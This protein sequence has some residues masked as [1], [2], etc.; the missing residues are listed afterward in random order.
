M[1]Q[2]NQSYLTRKWFV[3]VLFVLSIFAK[4]CLFHWLVF[5]SLLVSSLWKEPI[6]FIWFYLPKMAPA[7]IIGSFIFVSK[8][9]WW[10][11]I[12]NVFYDIWIIANLFY[13]RSNELLMNFDAIGMADNMHGFWPSLVAYFRWIFL[14]PLGITMIYA[15][16][17]YYSSHYS[18]GKAKSHDWIRCA[19]VFVLGWIM[20]VCTH[21]PEYLYL[22]KPT[23]EQALFLKLNKEILGFSHR[24]WKQFV[25]WYN[26]KVIVLIDQIQWEYNYVKNQS[27][28]Q[29]FTALIAH[30]C[31]EDKAK[32]MNI[33][34]DFEIVLSPDTISP[35][36][37]H[38][39]YFILVESLESWV[40]DDTCYNIAP[41]MS[42]LINQEHVL[43]CPHIK[44][45]VKQGNSGDG[46]MIV[47]TGL[48][49]I[50]Y[51]AAC[52]LFNHNTYPNYAHLFDTAV[53]INPCNGA[54][55]Q[56]DASRNYGYQSM[57]Q[58]TDAE[59]MDDSV[60]VNHAQ[61]IIGTHQHGT[62]CLLV[63]TIASHAPFEMEPIS[64]QFAD[65]NVSS[66]IKG[67]ING[68]H[69]TDSCLGDFIH[70]IFENPKLRE[71]TIAITGDHTFFKDA[72]LQ[73]F[74][75]HNYDISTPMHAD[76]PLIIYSPNIDG[77]IQITEQCYQMD[78]YP[79]IMALLGCQNYFWQGLG[80]NLLD[81]NKRKNRVYSEDDAYRLSDVLI[82]SNYF[83]TVSSPILDSI[84]IFWQ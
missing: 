58:R 19:V 22:P 8:H 84:S 49:P 4:G 52:M 14:I 29:Y 79:T 35:K 30:K 15:V 36:P 83:S 69:Y 27:L 51:G 81:E 34:E 78:I 56:C 45:Q 62:E 16:V 43:Y 39:L 60:I 17:V 7:I 75:G 70:S 41:N 67:Y 40:F 31:F 3:F 1:I 6:E 47:N 55:K 57:I 42:S 37:N 64:P 71:S 48:L 11:I 25:P 50:Q 74:H 33:P 53:V 38:N 24:H 2:F 20:Q 66:Q 63:L 82:R 68:V 59:W 21:I 73:E 54:W 72:V 61:R 76:C 46:Q 10:S 44:S 13:L 65:L 32:F 23:E 12:V 80:V 18:F 77:N 26:I 28:L 9:N 5:N